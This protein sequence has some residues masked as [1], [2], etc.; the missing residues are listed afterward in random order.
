[1]LRTRDLYGFTDRGD[2]GI[3]AVNPAVESAVLGTGVHTYR[4][5]SGNGDSCLEISID[6]RGKPAG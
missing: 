4:G 2:R 5:S 3:T 6:Y 1:M